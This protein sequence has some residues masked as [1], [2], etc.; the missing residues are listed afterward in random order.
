M[1][2]PIRISARAAIIE[3]DRILL[4]ECEDAHGLH[5]NFPGGGV[6]PGESLHE[7]VRR[8]VFEETCAEV[9]VGRLLLAYEVAPRLAALQNMEPAL[10]MIFQAQ[11]AG[12]AE[13]QMPSS[14]DTDQIGV[15]WVPLALISQA[16]DFP[17]VDLQ[18]PI[19]FELV[20]ALRQ[21]DAWNP[22]IMQA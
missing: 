5:Y 13:P 1:I 15:R 18:P 8:E 4:I 2:K 21:F 6:Q 11:L 20:A 19:G 16:P 9:E 22:H 7:A 10:A 14:P 17:Q 12:D 3:D